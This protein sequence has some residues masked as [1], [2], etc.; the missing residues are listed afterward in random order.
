MKGK[1]GS[2]GRVNIINMVVKTVLTVSFI[3]F[4]SFIIITET[5]S[6]LS[7]TLIYDYV[8]I[9]LFSACQY[10]SITDFS[11]LN[12]FATDTLRTDSKNEVIGSVKNGVWEYEY[13]EPY[14]ATVHDKLIPYT[15]KECSPP[16]N[17]TKPSCEDVTYYN[18][19]FKDVGRL[20]SV[21]LSPYDLIN[22]NTKL[23]AIRIKPTQNVR[24]C[25]E[26]ERVSTSEGFT[27]L[28]D[29]IPY[30]NGVTY[31][32]YAFINT[33]MSRR[34]TIQTNDLSNP[35]LVNDT[36]GID[37]GSGA[38]YIWC[39]NTATF[40]YNDTNRV[41]CAN[42][43][44]QIG[45]FLDEANGT[46]FGS[47]ESNLFAWWTMNG[48]LI[49]M[50]GG[51]TLTNI[52]TDSVSDGRVGH[53]RDF[54][55]GESDSMTT[56]SM[57]FNIEN[58][59]S[60]CTWYKWETVGEQYMLDYRNGNNNF[61]VLTSGI[62]SCRSPDMFIQGACASQVNTNNCP[63]A[64]IWQ[65]FCGVWNSTDLN[66]YVD[67]LLNG[68]GSCGG[69]TTKIFTD[70]H[71][72]SRFTGS[73]F[74]DGVI[75]NVVLFERELSSNEVMALFNNTN[76]DNYSFVGEIEDFVPPPVTPSPPI[77]IHSFIIYKLVDVEIPFISNYLESLLFKTVIF[78][79]DRLTVEGN[80]VIGDG[81]NVTNNTVTGGCI[82]YNCAQV[83]GCVTLGVCI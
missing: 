10:Y 67:G 39:E 29:I 48:S 57:D 75:D 73:T 43:T 6:G 4:A 40:I 46:V 32:E 27:T 65:H 35:F 15:V 28:V 49:D 71:I 51:K 38:Q 26:I 64:G 54:E 41:I 25:A 62:G 14:I 34:P 56:P 66:L 61:F 74:F 23:S 21:W 58:P 68:T 76:D 60:I 20:R 81:L 55:S 17:A 80:V 16:A 63:G 36:F 22:N 82:Q 5:V 24:F 47:F 52:G 3:L 33:S 42:D 53:A 50:V 59:F 9:E 12:T 7:P 83:G 37:L 70:M 1:K 77:P 18:Q 30:F 44:A 69:S 31:P 79:M 45:T 8:D 78:F 72:G 13:I 2:Q 19:T 11:T